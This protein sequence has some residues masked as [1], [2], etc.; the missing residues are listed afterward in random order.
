MIFRG[1]IIVISFKNVP[2]YYTGAND[3]ASNEKDVETSF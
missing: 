1:L 2:Q 3:R